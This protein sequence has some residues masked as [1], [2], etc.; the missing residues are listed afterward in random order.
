MDSK[1]N[2]YIA[3]NTLGDLGENTNK[4]S[5]D[6][7][8]TKLRS[9]GT[10]LWTKQW[11][12]SEHDS[13]RSIT[14]DKDDNLY[15]TGRMN[16]SEKGVFLVK[17]RT[18]GTKVWERRIGATTLD[19][20]QSVITDNSGNIY[21]VGTTHG[22]SDGSSEIQKWDIFLT[23]WDSDGSEIW[24]K[25]LNYPP[26]EVFTE[27]AVVDTKGNIIVTGRTRYE[28]MLLTKWNPDGTLLW[29]RKFEIEERNGGL[30]V[31]TDTYGNIF[32]TGY[33][34]GDLKT[35]SNKD[36]FGI[37][38][39]KWNPD[40]ILIWVEQWGT[41]TADGG[42]SVLIDDSGKIFVTGNTSGDLDGNVDRD[43]I[44]FDVF[45]TKWTPN[46]IKEWTKQFGTREDDFSNYMVIDNDYV[47]ILGNTE[48][49]FNGSSSYGLSDIFLMKLKK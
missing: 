10:E 20:G 25:Q 33:S 9:D 35:N 40:G 39:A 12:T 34:Q 47:Y 19:Y 24:R 49:S 36:I 32:V 48:G 22:N 17:M 18:D 2:I 44:R 45:L 23:K 15:I 21:V 1:N 31:T 43:G 6:A 37:F 28:E 11:G 5:S 30:S 4:G 16:N 7:F 38:L 42:T 13:I 41:H 14:F 46:G 3:G 27:E 8:I 29:I 26:F